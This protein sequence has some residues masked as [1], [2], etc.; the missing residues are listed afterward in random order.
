MLLESADFHGVGKKRSSETS[1]E[2]SL[3]PPPKLLVFSAK[4]AESVKRSAAD[5]ESYLASKP[6]SVDDMA[7]T[8]STKREVLAHRAFCVTDGQGDFELSRINK[9]TAKSPPSIIFTFT[10]QGAQS[11]QMGKDLIQGIPSFKH[12]IQRLDQLLAGLPIPPKW[13]LLGK[14]SRHIFL[15]YPLTDSR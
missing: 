7:Y 9:S 1:E 13:K 10:G 12:S 3:E 8:L 5:H 15:R 14:V 11:A 2:T 6:E 4:S